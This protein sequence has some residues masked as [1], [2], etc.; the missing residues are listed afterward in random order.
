METRERTSETER[1]RATVL[2]A[3]LTGFTALTEGLDPEEASA[4][5]GDCLTLLLGVGFHPGHPLV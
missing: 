3:D 2:F 5:I 4:I 1:R